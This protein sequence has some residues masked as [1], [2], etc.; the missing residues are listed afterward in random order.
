MDN[1]ME[2][3]KQLFVEYSG[4]QIDL[5]TFLSRL[6]EAVAAHLEIQRM[7]IWLLVQGGAALS[8]VDLYDAESG[9][10]SRGALHYQEDNPD[11]FAALSGQGKVVA[12]KVTADP[13][14]ASLLDSYYDPCQIEA[15]L[16]VAI[17]REGNMIGAIRCEQCGGER[18]WTDS[19]VRFVEQVASIVSRVR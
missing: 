19:D 5:A 18:I 15:V 17:M 6:N 13:S 12:S 16:D 10:H 1:I 3:M 2:V 8:S 11:Y 4:K 9:Q 7:G 14:L